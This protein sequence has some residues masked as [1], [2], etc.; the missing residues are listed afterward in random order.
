MDFY[1]AIRFPWSKGV[2]ATIRSRHLRHGVPCLP[3]DLDGH[4][5]AATR[6]LD[7]H[8]I[9]LHTV[10]GEDSF[11]GGRLQ[12]FTNLEEAK[13]Y[14]LQAASAS[15]AVSIPGAPRPPG[16]PIV[17]GSGCKIAGGGTNPLPAD[18]GVVEFWEDIDLR[19][20]GW[21][22]T[23]TTSGVSDLSKAWA[24]GFLWWGWKNAD[25]RI[26][27]VDVMTS[28]SG[29]TLQITPFPEDGTLWLSHRTRVNNLGD[30]G[31]NDRA[32]FWRKWCFA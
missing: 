11:T 8:G 31:W 26:S 30:L 2:D 28:Y 24:C 4:A 29:I 23:D 7:L 17:G 10:L 3:V 27:S 15:E 6:V 9:P 32:R 19:G 22:L 5:V 21:R 20:C 25:L 1:M 13:S 16:S 14:Q 18:S 12:I